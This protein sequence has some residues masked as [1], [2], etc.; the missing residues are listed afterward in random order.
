MKE[1]K[2][3]ARQLLLAGLAGAALTLGACFAVTQAGRD[4]QSESIV[5]A[6]RLIEERYI[7]DYDPDQVMDQALAGMVEGTG[8]RW[9]YYLNAQEY[10]AQN[11]RRENGYVGIGVTVGLDDPR[12]LVIQKVGTDSPAAQAGLTPGEVITAVD[13]AAVSFDRYQD[14]L[15]QIQGE[16]GTQVLLTVLGLDGAVRETAVLRRAIENDSVAYQMLKNG[17]GYVRVMN[18]YTHSAEQMKKAVETLQAQGAEALVFDMRDNGGGYVAQLTDMLDYLLPEG[19]IF[20]SQARGE[21]EEVVVSDAQC[22]ALPMAT[23]VNANTYSAAEIFAAQLRESVNAPI[24]GVETSGKGYFQQAIALDNGGALNL[25]TG[26][27]C[28]GGGV[29][30]VGSG[31]TLD[32]EVALSGEEETLLQAGKLSPE[33]DR[34]LQA[35]LSLLAGED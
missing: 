18:F 26:R 19:P 4:P 7:G 22:V 32:R 21:Q 15:D 6:W 8:D 35:A 28:T 10:A 25:S 31:V 30:L 13:G 2:Y 16:E 1:K 33:E 23:L 34:Q 24:I 5:E 14:A 9:S 12:G 29:S 3:T 17:V 20:R 27:Y 11:R